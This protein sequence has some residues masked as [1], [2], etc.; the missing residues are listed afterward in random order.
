MVA[1]PPVVTSLIY[2]VPRGW[3]GGGLDLGAALLQR[4]RPQGRDLPR[5]ACAGAAQCAARGLRCTIR[6]RM[7]L[8]RPEG[9]SASL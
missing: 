8:K 1:T 5:G 6:E 3:A 2:K 9:G 7:P 4:V